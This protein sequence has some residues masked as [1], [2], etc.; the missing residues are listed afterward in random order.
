MD[1][2]QHGG[3]PLKPHAGVDRRFRQRHLAAVGEALELHEDEIPDL[4]EAVAVGVRRAG[5]SARNVIAMVEENLRTRSARAGVAHRPEIV[6]GVDADDA[7]FGQAG[8][9]A[10]QLERFVVGVIDGDGEAVCVDAEILV[11]KRPGGVDRLFLEIIAEG[12]VA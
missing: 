11:D 7:L 6:V 12:E 1:A 3:D 9:L 8:D 4:D 10:P 2:L 5:R